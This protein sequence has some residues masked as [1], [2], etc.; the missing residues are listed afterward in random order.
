MYV[1]P[2][3]HITLSNLGFWRTFRPRDIPRNQDT[4]EL[5]RL[6][7]DYKVSYHESFVDGLFLHCS[8]KWFF[9]Y[10]SSHTQA[11]CRASCCH[12]YSPITVRTHPKLN[13]RGLRKSTVLTAR[14]P[15]A[16]ISE[17]A[18]LSQLLFKK[19][20]II[21]KGLE[22]AADMTRPYQ[23]RVTK[24]QQWLLNHQRLPAK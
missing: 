19:R 2:K 5:H 17:Q 11:V 15:M 4:E 13:A 24:G 22:W 6:P 3:I 12:G 14:W 23:R 21:V 16:Q 20:I 18:F 8:S 10:L 1:R 7:I 9:S